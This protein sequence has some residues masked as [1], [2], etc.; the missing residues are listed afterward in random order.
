MDTAYQMQHLDE[1]LTPQYL[2][3]VIITLVASVIAVILRMISQF[4]IGSVNVAD[5]YLILIAAVLTSLPSVM[6]LLTTSRLVE[7]QHRQLA[8]MDFRMVSGNIKYGPE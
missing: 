3:A 7:S 4:M 1:N 5:N 8:S 2:A 6:Y